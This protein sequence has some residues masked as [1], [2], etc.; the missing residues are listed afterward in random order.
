[1]NREVDWHPEKSI[2]TALVP[3]PSGPISPTTSGAA[4]DGPTAG[5]VIFGAVVHP[6]DPLG[7]MV[8][9]VIC[10]PRPT[11]MPLFV[12]VNVHTRAFD[13]PLRALMAAV[14]TGAMGEKFAVTLVGPLSVNSA[15]SWS[16]S[17][18]R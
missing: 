12:N 16:P 6:G 13:A 9:P 18:R 17:A 5:V 14:S 15:G 8:S 2:V 7:V 10:V 1:M 11:P 4:V 3:V